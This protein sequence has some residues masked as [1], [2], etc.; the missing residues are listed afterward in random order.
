[1][2]EFVAGV[3]IAVLT[4]CGVVF[5][6]LISL[7]THRNSKQINDAVNHRHQRADENG[8]APL[9]LYDL[10]IENHQKIERTEQKLDGLVEWKESYCDSPLNTGKGVD[11][12]LKQFA[13]LQL[14]VEQSTCKMK[15]E[16]NEH[17]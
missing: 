10:A 1:M 5:N 11:E 16:N 13:E 8:K 6:G 2:N 12:F 15:D 4:L 7:M 9:K 14:K 3:I 17:D